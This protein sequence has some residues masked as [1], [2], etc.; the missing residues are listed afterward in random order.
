MINRV[1][2]QP[3]RTS[4]WL[5]YHAEMAAQ[6]PLFVRF[7]DDRK[8]YY[9][10]ASFD[11]VRAAESGYIE[12]INCRWDAEHWHE[13]PREWRSFPDMLTKVFAGPNGANVGYRTAGEWRIK[14]Y[15]DRNYSA[16]VSDS[17][18]FI[19]IRN[20]GIIYRWNG[21]EHSAGI[22][23]SEQTLKHAP[24]D[25]IIPVIRGMLAKKWRGFYDDVVEFVLEITGIRRTDI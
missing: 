22:F 18:E 12:V 21:V 17:D 4:G 23:G 14:F 10:D 9:T 2:S 8:P 3:P 11:E 15:N 6:Y 24:D 25:V 13:T 1:Y 16:W 19:D 20:D 7:K 5:T